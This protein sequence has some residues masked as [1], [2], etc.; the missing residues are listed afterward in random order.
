MAPAR[1]RVPKKKSSEIFRDAVFW[2]IHFGSIL[3]S[4]A[5][6]IVAPALMSPLQSTMAVGFSVDFKALQHPPQPK[7]SGKV[8]LDDLATT[9]V[10]R[11][12]CD[13][14]FGTER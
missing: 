11:L 3:H 9:L 2:V 13:G 1:T 6:T 5:Q 7:L 12:S 8:Q 4:S 14:L 10:K